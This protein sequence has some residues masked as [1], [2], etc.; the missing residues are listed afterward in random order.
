MFAAALHSW[1]Q[2][3]EYCPSL[4]RVTKTDDQRERHRALVMAATGSIGR[5]SARHATSTLTFLSHCALLTTSLA[6]IRLS[7]CAPLPV[8][9][10]PYSTQNVPYKAIPCCGSPGRRRKPPASFPTLVSP[11][12]T[13][14]HDN[15]TSRLLFRSPFQTPRTQRSGYNSSA[16]TPGLRQVSFLASPSRRPSSPADADR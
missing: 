10:T 7:T 12:P 9:D 1:L 14:A 13:L 16:P 15:L 6:P 5:R 4:S 2:R 11:R 8:T 3:M